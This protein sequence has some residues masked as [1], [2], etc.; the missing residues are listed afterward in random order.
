MRNIIR[1][2]VA[3]SMVVVL[4]IMCAIT[5]FNISLPKEFYIYENNNL[6]I[7]EYISTSAENSSVAK[8]VNN[9]VGGS[10]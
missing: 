9:T 2:S 4:I 3:F 10:Y 5:Y 8:T 7:N 6:K 1:Y